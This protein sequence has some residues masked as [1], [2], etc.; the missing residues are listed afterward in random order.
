M[1]Y[2]LDTKNIKL[3]FTTNN[4]IGGSTAPKNVIMIN[5]SS[6]SRSRILILQLPHKPENL[7]KLNLHL[8]NKQSRDR[9]VLQNGLTEPEELEL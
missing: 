9:R 6:S 2:S 7:M 1:T 8:N 4:T 3:E 5:P